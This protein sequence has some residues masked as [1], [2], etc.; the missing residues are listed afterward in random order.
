MTERPKTCAEVLQT[1]VDPISAAL[2]EIELENVLC[3]R[4]ELTAPFGL[5]VPVEPGQLMFHIAIAD[6]CLLVADGEATTMQPRH[7]ALVTKPGVHKLCSTEEVPTEDVYGLPTEVIGERM[8]VLHYGG[9]GRSTTL[10]CGVAGLRHPLSRLA[11]NAL[12]DIIHTDALGVSDP[13]VASALEALVA[14]TRGVRVGGAARSRLLANLLVI[15]GVRAWLEGREETALP[16][17]FGALRHPRIGRVL[18]ALHAEPGAHWSV[19]RMA[20]DTHMSK[21]AFHDAFKKTVG[22]TPLR[23]L[24]QWRMEYAASSLANTDE[25]VA[26]VARAC[27]YDSES[28]FSRAFRREFGHSPGDERR[29]AQSR[30]LR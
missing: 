14:E 26:E 17:W 1:E 21:S 27:G 13:L 10:V 23:Y 2:A 20:A 22:V 5:T 8:E 29:M 24:L 16:R 6:E 28:A 15:E 4:S 25:S 12:P 7:F 18:K 3:V 11:L 19:E 30:A 9:G